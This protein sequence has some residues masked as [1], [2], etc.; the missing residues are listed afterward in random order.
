MSGQSGQLE[1]NYTH[2]TVIKYFSLTSLLVSMVTARS[3]SMKSFS[4]TLT[5]KISNICTSTKQRSIALNDMVFH[6]LVSIW[7][8]VYSKSEHFLRI[9]IVPV[10]CCCCCCPADVDVPGSELTGGLG[11][12]LSRL[13]HSSYSDPSQISL[14]ANSGLG[15]MLI[16]LNMCIIRSLLHVWKFGNNQSVLSLSRT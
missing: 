9:I 11:T 12:L 15:K 6:K 5:H 10:L 2:N 4:S 13:P 14:Q 7:A 8:L 16:W 3:L 1:G